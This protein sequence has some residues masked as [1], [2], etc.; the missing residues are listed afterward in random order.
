V[1]KIWKEGTKKIPEQ[2]DKIK[3]NQYQRKQKDNTKSDINRNGRSKIIFAG[4]KSSD[5]KSHH[6]TSVIW[7]LW[8]DNLFAGM[9]PY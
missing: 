5:M 1:N 3:E 9:L 6:T 7:K 4:T 2:N 8:L